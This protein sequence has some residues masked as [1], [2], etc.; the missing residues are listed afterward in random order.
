MSEIPI[1]ST[2][3]RH[4]NRFVVSRSDRIILQSC[5]R[6]IFGAIKLICFLWAIRATSRAILFYQRGD[7]RFREYV[8]FNTRGTYETRCL[9]LRVKRKLGLNEP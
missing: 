8:H 4:D 9:I 6:N 3:E 2:D 5:R 1:V 7:I